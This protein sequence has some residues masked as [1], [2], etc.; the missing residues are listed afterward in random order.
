MG[1]RRQDETDEGLPRRFTQINDTIVIDLCASAIRA[2][3]GSSLPAPFPRDLSTVNKYKSCRERPIIDI[4]RTINFPTQQ[5]KLETP[6]FNFQTYQFKFDDASHLPPLRLRRH[7]ANR[8]IP[9][10]HCPPKP[11][12]S[13]KHVLPICRGPNKSRSMLWDRRICGLF[14]R[15]FYLSGVWS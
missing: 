4:T 12:Q 8:G 5:T 15:K 1:S 13:R 11:M 14:G 6:Q 9:R 10:P 7:E 3:I 2:F